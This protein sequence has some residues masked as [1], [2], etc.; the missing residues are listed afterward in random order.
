MTQAHQSH[1]VAYDEQ[2]ADASL[3]ETFENPDTSGYVIEHTTE[4]FTSLCPKTGHPDFAA[5]ILRYGPDQSCVELKS[6][7][8]YYHSYRNDGI[9]YEAVTNKIRDDL[10]QLMSPKWLELI[11][12]WRGRGG[13]HSRI[14]A[15]HGEVPK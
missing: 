5:I 6:L 12:K 9:F 10:V 1:H 3:L 8:L 15:T 14:I 7:K 2:M 13:L 4:E 11:T